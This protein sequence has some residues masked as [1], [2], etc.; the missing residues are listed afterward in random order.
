MVAT[1]ALLV[2]VEAIGFV[3]GGAQR[4]IGL[5]PLNLQPSELMKP[6]IVLACAY[7]Y[8]MLPAQRDQGLDAR[9]GRR[10]PDRHS[11]SH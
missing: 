2:V 4:W 8:A 6:V 10:A 3:G 11:R 5:G 9:S 1:L 7:F